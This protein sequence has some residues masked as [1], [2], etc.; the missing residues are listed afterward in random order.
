MD[1]PPS[2]QHPISSTD[3]KTLDT[4][5]RVQSVS[6]IL[7]NAFPIPG[8]DYRIGLD[9]FLGLLPGGGDTVGAFLSAY[10]VLE[11]LQLRLPRETLIRMVTNLLVDSILGTIPVI[12]DL[13][14]VTWKANARNVALLKAHLRNPNKARPADRWFVL[15][16]AIVVLGIVFG[17]FLLA[18]FLVR[19]LF[20]LGT[21]QPVG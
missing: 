16:M 13:F 4:L 9:P 12:G 7:D 10:I 2:P 3:P 6:H 19:T 11:S 21:S 18:F 8:T 14:D 1:S 15:L 5:K 20:T 17:I